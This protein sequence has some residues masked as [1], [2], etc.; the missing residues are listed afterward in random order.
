MTNPSVKAAS[1]VAALLAITFLVITFLVIPQLADAEP[2][3]SADEG[4]WYRRSGDIVVRLQPINR[5]SAAAPKP[6]SRRPTRPSLPAPPITTQPPTT[7]PP[8]DPDLV[9]GQDDTPPSPS[10][11][12]PGLY[13]PYRDPVYGLDLQRVTTADGTRFDRN[14]Y[15]RRQA[16]NT[17][18]T[19]FLTYHG[20]AEYRVYN[21]SDGSLLRALDIGPGAEPQWHPTE[22]DTMRHIAGDNA[23][24]GDLAY[25]ETNVRTGQRTQIADLTARIQARYPAALYLQ[26]RDEGSPS[27]DGNRSAWILYDGSE[28]PIGLVHYDLASDRILGMADIYDGAG[29]LDWVST[30]PSGRYVM[31]G[32]AEGT[33]VYDADLQ[34]RREVYNGADH[35]DIAIA[36]DGRDTYVFQNFGSDADAGWLVAVDLET[37][38]RTRLFDLYGTDGNTSIH[39]SGKGYNKPG[40][41]LVSTY[42]CKVPGAWSCEKVMAVELAPQGRVLNLAHTYNCGD[43]YWTETH[44]VVNRDFT[45]VYFNSD[46]GS[47]G[48]DAEVYLIDLPSFS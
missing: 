25:Y 36:A 28:N 6:I 18:G 32:H 13:Q 19:L 40:W 46:G 10:W 2:N 7:Q 29:R 48:I 21:R 24:I 43:N 26:D 9:W 4:G 22:A 27:A 12:K 44:A 38:A 20:N 15:S 11:T 1:P 47:C 30:S 23:S 16:E 3:G 42:N 35:S 14:T 41:V 39:I 17:D 8:N 45:R 37:L 5:V 34:N 31:A 33:Y